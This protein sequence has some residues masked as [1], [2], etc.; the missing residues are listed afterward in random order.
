MERKIELV[1][2][3]G[4]LVGGYA[5]IVGS[6]KGPPPAEGE[7]PFCGAEGQSANYIEPTE[8]GREDSGLWP[9]NIDIR[10]KNGMEWTMN[11]RRKNVKGK[12]CKINL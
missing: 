12:L 11:P 9:K 8:Q 2:S 5:G 7:R 1:G 10:S 4:W 3:A 6:R